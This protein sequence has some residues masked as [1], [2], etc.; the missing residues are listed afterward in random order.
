[1]KKRNEKLLVLGTK[2]VSL[3]IVLATLLAPTCRNAWYQP[4]EPENLAKLLE[5]KH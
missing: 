5:R 4:E 3:A 1:M 2:V